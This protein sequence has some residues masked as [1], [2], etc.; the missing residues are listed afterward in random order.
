MKYYFFCYVCNKTYENH[1]LTHDFLPYD[2]K[3]TVKQGACDDCYKKTIASEPE[4]EEPD[5]KT[6]I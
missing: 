3:F 1:L 2:G 6:G 4:V 5:Q